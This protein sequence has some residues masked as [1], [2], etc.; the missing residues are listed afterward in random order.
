M[1]V[2]GHRGAAALAPENTLQAMQAGFEAGADMLE[3]DVR[4]TSDGIPVVIHDGNLYR[5]HRLRISIGNTTLAELR[6]QTPHQPIPTLT[7]V[8]DKFFG[9]ILLNIELKSKGSGAVVADIISRNYVK[10][11]PNWDNVLFS[12]FKASELGDVRKISK[13]ANLALLHDQNPYLFIAYQ[14]KLHL[15]AVGFHRLYANR[16]AIEIAKKSGIF[17]YA[18]TV[19]RPYAALLLQRQGIDAIVTNHPDTILQEI[20]KEKD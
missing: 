18:Y 4:V 9:K 2:I 15:T 13:H 12:S 16:F 17:T 5:T 8:L 1:L 19:D 14:R 11:L 20:K 10:R 3:F 6:A 7:E